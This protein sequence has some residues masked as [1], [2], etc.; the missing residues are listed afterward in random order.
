MAEAI[1]PF[2]TT[3]ALA[4]APV[5][6]DTTG[7]NLNRTN[8]QLVYTTNVTNQSSSS[9]TMASAGFVE[10]N[11][12]SIAGYFTNDAGYYVGNPTSMS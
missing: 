11:P 12:Y 5:M 2:R 1:G 4:D 8:P 10:L 3:K 6:S 9:V 7:T